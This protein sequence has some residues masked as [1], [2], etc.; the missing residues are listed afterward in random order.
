MDLS[1]VIAHYQN[2]NAEADA[3]QVVRQERREAEAE[4]SAQREI[5]DRERE[6]KMGWLEWIGVKTE[7]GGKVG[8]RGGEERRSMGISGDANETTSGRL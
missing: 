3:A 6:K 5:D 4:A 1:G 7:I 8:G 2:I